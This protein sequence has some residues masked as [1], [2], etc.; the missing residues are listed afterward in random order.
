M[1]GRTEVPGGP[2]VGILALQ[3]GFAAHAAVLHSLGARTQEVRQPADL[4]GCD[5]LVLPGGESTVLTRLLMLP[6]SGPGSGRDWQP[7]PLFLAIRDFGRRRPVMGTCAGLIMLARPGQDSRVH[8]LDL[9]DVAVERNAYGRQTESFVEPIRLDWP[10]EPALAT[11]GAGE[12]ALTTGATT[13]AAG[14]VAGEVALA[15]GGAGLVAGETAL[16]AAGETARAAVHAA[17]GTSLAGQPY[18]AS[19]IRAPRLRDIGPGV[20][21]LAR[22]T[23][24]GQAEPVMVRQGLILGL[25]FHP[26]LNPADRRI[27][28]YFLDMIPAVA[29]A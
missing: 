13:R 16:V 19:F 21:V 10:P 7:G 23:A 14:H 3:G 1:P 22:A 18:P 12:A 29:P 24:H 15:T 8:A 20:T 11:G 27:H 26:E 5:A 28:R 6:H 17:G 4:A 9:L 2:L 25:A